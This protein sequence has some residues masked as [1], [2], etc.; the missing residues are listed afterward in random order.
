MRN[1]AIVG[2]SLA[3]LNAAI[4]LRS[5]GF[6]GRLVLIGEEAAA[7]YDRPPLSKEIIRGTWPIEQT[8]LPYDAQELNADWR[9]GTRVVALDAAARRLELDTGDTEEFDGLVL[10]T[11]AAPRRLGR[12]AL[13]GVH[14]IRSREDALRLR[15]ELA[16]RPARVVVIGGGF[17]GQEVA[18]SCRQMGLT[19]TLVEIDSPAQRVLGRE[20]GLMLADLH[21]RNG[22][23]VRLGVSA[24]GFEGEERVTGV[25]LSDGTTLPS[26]VVV[27]G[28]G[29]TPNV[30]WLRYS[31]LNLDDGI[32][33][34]R[35]CLAAP[36]I[37]A[38]GDVARWPNELFEECRRIEHWDNAIRQGKHAA[39]RLLDPRATTAQSVGYSPVPWFWSD[40]YG[41]KLQLAGSTLGYDEI[42]ITHGSVESG[43]FVAQY[44]RGNRLIGVFA[45][46]SANTLIKYRRALQQRIDWGQEVVT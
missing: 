29:V 35:T 6:R 24:L 32:V 43:K 13:R 17:I 4:A 19:V 45:L 23:D 26:A 9:L 31:G 44:R 33:C 41:Q 37:V 34:D 40:Q 8:N 7:P 5:E 27:V 10:A 11:G 14:V 2:A 16:E 42:A 36:G 21:R 38:A 46:G 30:E 22:V 25:H 1:I 12:Q 15:T 39:L 18:S 3:G 20:I 28:L